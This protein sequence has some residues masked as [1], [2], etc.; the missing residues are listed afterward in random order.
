M[1]KVLFLW[2]MGILTQCGKSSKVLRSIFKT[3]LKIS[4]IEKPFIIKMDKGPAIN[5][6]AIKIWGSRNVKSYKTYSIDLTGLFTT[7]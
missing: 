4:T 3:F 5:I 2:K 7:R 6:N 1:M